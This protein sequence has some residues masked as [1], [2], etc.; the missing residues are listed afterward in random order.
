[1]SAGS[2]YLWFKPSGVAYD[3]LMRTIRQLAEE[4]S[5]PVFEP[6]I[7]LIGNLEGTE[8]ELAKQTEQLAHQ[9]E[10][11]KAVL[12]EPSYR[13]D[14]FQCLFI[15]VEQTCSIMDAHA[16]ATNFFHKPNQAFMPHVSLAYGSYPESRKRL[17]IDKLPPDV[18][19]CFDATTL[20]LIRADSQ[21][22]KDWHQIA[23]APLTAV[24]ALP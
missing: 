15:L 23:A 24:S 22:P 9:L 1:M 20:Y 14:H 16:I 5:G 11:F 6:H 12:T 7:S 21:D 18:R 13:D 19:T 4:L 8:E 2:Y 17:I 3:I 10:P